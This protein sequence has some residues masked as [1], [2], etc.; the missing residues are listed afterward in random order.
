MKI[1]N[2][3]VLISI[4]S[5]LEDRACRQAGKMRLINGENVLL[6]FELAELLQ[7]STQELIRKVRANKGRFP[8]DFLIKIPAKKF[9]QDFRQLL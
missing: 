4:D 7:V 6:D 9:L 2:D 3:T 5:L 8:A 1:S